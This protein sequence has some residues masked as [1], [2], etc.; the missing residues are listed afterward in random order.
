MSRENPAPLFKMKI[1]V[2][3]TPQCYFCRSQRGRNLILVSEDAIGNPDLPDGMGLN[4]ICKG[5]KYRE[6]YKRMRLLY[7][8]CYRCFYIAPSKS[9]RYR[10]LQEKKEVNLFKKLFLIFIF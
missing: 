10:T 9:Y 7:W 8:V 2:P 3:S 1:D 6:N 5:I 4:A